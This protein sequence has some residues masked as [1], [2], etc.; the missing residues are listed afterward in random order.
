MKYISI[1]LETTGLD[2]SYC[3]ILEFGAAYDDETS[4]ISQLKTF[5][6]IVLH[7]KIVGEPYALW[8]NAELLK[9][10][11]EYNPITSPRNLFCQEDQLLPEFADWL[12]S[13][14]LNPLSVVVAGKNFA[15]FDLQFINR[16]PGYGCRV[17]FHRRIADPAT[18]YLLPTDKELPNTQTCLKRA[19]LPEFVA[20][21][22][23]DDAIDVIR[24]Q[25]HG[26]ERLWEKL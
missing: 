16:L 11:A 2:D 7:K 1:D 12:S 3:Q 21:K 18:Y 20:H 22:A 19:G 26:Q 4:H 9:E 13:I 24:L 17:N 5:R 14:G 6:R 10:I 15:N 23:V 25:R 8:L